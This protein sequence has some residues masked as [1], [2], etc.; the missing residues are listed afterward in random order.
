[1]F[2]VS[3]LG[4]SLPLWAELLALALV[5]A[6]A[7]F[8][9]GML[10]LGGGLFLVPTLVLLFGFDIHF[11]IAASLI[12]VTG[13]SSGAAVQ[14][15][16]R[17][18]TDLRI[19]TFLESGTVLGGVLGALLA[20][21]LL[22][23]RGD[24]L[25]L[26]FVPVVLIAA[27]LT[28]AGIRVDAPAARAPDGIARRL[29]LW[30]VYFDDRESRRVPYA[31]SRS[32]AAFGIAVSAGVASGL[33]GIGGGVF[34]VPAMNAVMGIPL[35]VAVATSNYMLGIT[36]AAGALVYVVSGVVVLGWVVPIAV[37]TLLGA[38]AGIRTQQLA[39][40]RRL[41]GLLVLVLVAAAVV[42]FLRGIGVIA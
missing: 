1:V 26:A 16:Q 36:A 30:G 40:I 23:D 29:R 4:S 7:G 42:M 22:R 24:I 28:F 15:Y 2:P 13:T 21:T 10:G 31:A 27:Y 35:R 6:G 33:L 38:L 11:A 25:V 3:L 39:P 9:G 18:L 37:G 34:K 14:S 32:S 8:L 20:I 19:G 12:S 5:A 41:K 17:R